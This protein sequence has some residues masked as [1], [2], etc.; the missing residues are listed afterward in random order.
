MV[1]LLIGIENDDDPVVVD[2]EEDRGMVGVWRET[3]DQ[4]NYAPGHQGENGHA[5][6]TCA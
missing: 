1:L 3:C 6:Q 2:P 4:P 5:A